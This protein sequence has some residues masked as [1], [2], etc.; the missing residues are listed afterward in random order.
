MISEE[1]QLSDGDIACD[2][3]N[4]SAGNISSTRD[5]C[6]T[7]AMFEAS[8]AAY[9]LPDTSVSM[10]ESNQDGVEGRSDSFKVLYNVACMFSP[11]MSQMLTKLCLFVHKTL[12]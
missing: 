7:Q 11:E 9:S 5:C 10:P 4:E 6:L 2:S 3:E 8:P 12:K 1:I